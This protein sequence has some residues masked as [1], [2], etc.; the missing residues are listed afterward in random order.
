M[1]KLRRLLWGSVS[2]FSILANSLMPFS[3]ARAAA[4][5]GDDQSLTDTQSADALIVSPQSASLSEDIDRIVNALAD[6]SEEVVV[7][8]NIVDPFAQDSLDPTQILLKALRGETLLPGEIAVL[9]QN[10]QGYLIPGFNP[11]NFGDGIQANANDIA[12]SLHIGPYS[13]SN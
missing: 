2:S 10:G 1:S 3:Q 12:R 13:T 7:A 9:L 4:T 11:N 5:T 6:R 8:Q